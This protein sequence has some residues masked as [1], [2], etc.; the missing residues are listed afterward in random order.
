MKQD[1]LSPAATL[2]EAIKQI[3]SQ[4]ATGRLLGVS[5]AAVWAWLNE[6]KVLPAEHVLRVEEATGI[7][8]HRLR[9]DVYGPEPAEHAA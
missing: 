8:R 4:T 3:G 9:P 7:S 6:G 2:R 1:P 5:Q